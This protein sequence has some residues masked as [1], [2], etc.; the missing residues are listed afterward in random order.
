[1]PWW[2]RWLQA[3]RIA[4]V[5][6][7]TIRRWEGTELEPTVIDGT[8]YFEA[9][10]VARLRRVSDGEL[11]AQAFQFFEEDKTPVEVVIE[12]RQPAERIHLLYT[13][14]LEMGDYIVVEG[15]GLLRRKWEVMYGAK[16]T[17][18]VVQACA[19]AVL[20]KASWRA[21]VE[22]DLDEPFSSAGA[23]DK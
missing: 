1:M 2:R 5:S 14:W 10:D 4:G 17:R 19:E 15:R 23:V 21:A 6:V 16:L 7:S 11:A 3:A 18:E 8:H 20:G 13:Q 12:L 9:Q 22:R